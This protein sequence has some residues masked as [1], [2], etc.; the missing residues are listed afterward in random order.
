MFICSSSPDISMAQSTN[1][2]IS[3][4]DMEEDLRP[5][6]E[7]FTSPGTTTKA[8]SGDSLDEEIAKTRNK[9]EEGNRN[10]DF[11]NDVLS[12]FAGGEI[13]IKPNDQK[14]FWLDK[15]KLVDYILKQSI[16]K[17]LSTEDTLKETHRIIRASKRS[18]AGIIQYL[19]YVRKELKYHQLGLYALNQIKEEKQ[20]KQSKAMNVCIYSGDELQTTVPV[21]VIGTA[22]EF[23]EEQRLQQE[24]DEE[25]LRYKHWIEAGF[26]TRAGPPS[27]RQ[28]CAGFVTSKIFSSS[29]ALQGKVFRLRGG[30]S[31]F[32]K[33]IIVPLQHMEQSYGWENASVGDVVYYKNGHVAIV[34]SVNP[35]S[36]LTKDESESIFRHQLARL[37]GGMSLADSASMFPLGRDDDPLWGK[38][39]QPTLYKLKLGITAKL[40]DGNLPCPDNS[41]EDNGDTG[42]D[43]WTL[44]DTVVV[45]LTKPPQTITSNYTLRK[46]YK[47]KV[48]ASGTGSIWEGTSEGIDARFCYSENCGSKKLRDRSGLLTIYD[49]AYHP[50]DHKNFHDDHKYIYEMLGWDKPVRFKIHTW[51]DHWRKNNRSGKITLKIYEGGKRNN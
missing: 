16:D 20:A 8:S 49:N 46:N 13:F 7:E 9:I 33:N 18:R 27:K 25:N 45:P 12:R 22:H 51:I 4:S 44:K 21:N 5:F 38:H 39:G 3:P 50:V 15:D 11:L 34:D 37:L 10:L 29:S 1:P 47:Y 17:E 41:Q 43:Q 19:E 6:I 36:I 35:V 30:G 26:Y 28:D 42:S 14:G 2:P 31:G 24:R 48:E 40:V 23:T 32:Y